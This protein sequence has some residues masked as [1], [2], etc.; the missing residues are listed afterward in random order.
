MSTNNIPQDNG[1][2]NPKETTLGRKWKYLSRIDQRFYAY[3]FWQYHNFRKTNALQPDGSFFGTN[4]YYQ[5]IFGISKWSLIRAKKRLQESGKIRYITHQGRGKATYYFLL[6]T[7]PKPLKSELQKE[8][9]RP[10]LNA[11]EIKDFAKEHGKERAL[12]FYERGGYTSEEI[13]TALEAP[14]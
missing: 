5:E 3:L 12:T 4:E 6:D 8:Q 2:V 9:K 1:K 13:K 7:T 11:K 10:P 14:N